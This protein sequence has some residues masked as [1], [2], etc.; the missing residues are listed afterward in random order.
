MLEAKVEIPPEFRQ[1]P[2]E[3]GVEQEMTRSTRI[4]IVKIL[5]ITGLM[6]SLSPVR[7]LAAQPAPQSP[8]AS[9]GLLL[10]LPLVGGI[11]DPVVAP[12]VD[13]VVA[14]TLD[15]VVELVAPVTDPVVEE[16]VAP[17]LE[18]VVDD[19]VAPLV[20]PV[21]DNVVAPVADDVVAPIVDDAVAPIVE[22]VVSDVVAPVVEPVVSD[23]VAPIVDPVVNT[24]AAPVVDEVIAPVTQPIVSEGIAPIVAPVNNALV[25]SDQQAGIASAI[26]STLIGNE[27]VGDGSSHTGYLAPVSNVVTAIGQGV[28]APASTTASAVANPVITIVGTT[29]DGAIAPVLDAALPGEASPIT[30]VVEAAIT[31]LQSVVMPIIVPVIDT[32]ATITNPVI[33]TVGGVASNLSTSVSQITV[34]VVGV[35]TT[36]VN[37]VVETVQNV[38]VP[39]VNIVET[40]TD[41]V[42]H[43]VNE[44]VKPVVEIV[45]PTAPSVPDTNRAG[46]HRRSCHADTNCRDADPDSSSNRG[47]RNSGTTEDGY[48]ARCAFQPLS[49]DRGWAGR[50]HAAPWQLQ[51]PNLTSSTGSFEH[52]FDQLRDTIESQA[53][54]S[55][56]SAIKSPQ[57]LAQRQAAMPELTIED[58]QQ[59][60]RISF[61]SATEPGTLGS[62]GSNPESP[63]PL[64]VSGLD[65]NTSRHERDRR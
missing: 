33:Q 47:C 2:E 12:L 49:S 27:T 44:T 5:V 16:V 28:L 3:F 34:P 22:P 32:V 6:M 17:I 35:V 53:G 56:G 39:V 57:E 25:G 10:S 45:A 13:D 7:A 58:L 18:P 40:I 38:V 61:A 37:P 21:V 9:R 50:G 62:P 36:I 48:A 60:D 8:A 65:V 30:Q 26:T 59:I 24:V 31:P 55:A 52:L 29:A 23:V 4:F 42:V 54:A 20:D 1:E 41:P 11:L 19:V 63:S 46:A 43:V 14:P 15:P 51:G 64:A